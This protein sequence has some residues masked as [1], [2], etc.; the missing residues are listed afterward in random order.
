MGDNMYKKEDSNQELMEKE[1]E[2]TNYYYDEENSDE[3]YEEF[4]DD[5]FKVK[6]NKK[7]IGRR[8]ENIFF[9]I[10]III[11]LLAV[12][13]VI[14]ITNYDK[15]PF[16]AIPVKTYKDGGTTEYYGIG[17]KVIKYNQLQGR[18]D[19]EIGTW[20]LKYN[21]EP[22]TLQDIDLAI[23]MTENKEATYE[24]YDKKFVRIVSTLYKID[25]ENHRILI[26]Y[27]DEGGKY[28]L[29]ILC[30][31]VEEQEIK[32]FETEKEITIIGTINEFQKKTSNSNNGIYIN[33]CFAEQ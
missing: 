21:T 16:F 25:L 7:S 17:Y 1:A 4:N 8:I 27:Q 31:M 13:D 3:E 32:D 24:K 2:I 19:K 33:N 20:S 9:A 23:E 14:C 5:D 18:R 28:T 15:G 12:I 30:N 29:D 22:I 6:K 26:G 10:V 11:L